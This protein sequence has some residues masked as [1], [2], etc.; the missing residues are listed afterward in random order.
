MKTKSIKNIVK[1]SFVFFL[2]LSF[3][4]CESDDAEDNV[5]PAPPSSNNSY[6]ATVNLS[7]MVNGAAL[8]MN[9]ANLPYT[10]A[11]GQSF[12]VSKVQY[13]VSDITFNKADGSSF[14]IEE[15]HYVDLTD[16]S[17]LEFSPTTK[18]P[19]G[20]Y[21][22]ISFTF[23]FDG[24][25][26]VDGQYTDLNTVGWNWPTMLGGGY[27]FM[28]LEG[29]YIDSLADTSEFKT[30]MGTARDMSSGT[31]VF[32]ENHLN[33][34]LPNSAVTVDN[35]ITLD[36]TMNIEKWYT[37]PNDWDFNT[38]NAP[39]MPIYDAQKALNANGADVFEVSIM[40]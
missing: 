25:D 5:T 13:L 15:Y 11:M 38:W 27:H 8:Q 7:Q 22:S 40:K 34:V 39:I 29:N 3:F 36:L 9:T 35:N 26:N 4:A 28:R 19:E 16:Q 6:S 20:T 10:T 23:G 2:A 12:N 14:T 30:H 24:D 21:S 37:T 31:A 17:S 1:L 32:E 18:I 33:V